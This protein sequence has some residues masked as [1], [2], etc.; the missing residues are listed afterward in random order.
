MRSNIMKMDKLLLL[1]TTF[2]F[3]L[4]LFMILSASSV[5]ASLYGEPYHYFIRQSIILFISFIG[6]VFIMY[7]PL[8]FFKKISFI[9][10]LIVLGLLIGVDAY[11]I[12]ANKAQS[13]LSLGFFNLQP[14]E[15][16]KAAI[17]LFMA[18]YYDKHYKSNNFMII[19]FP[20]LTALLMSYFVYIQPDLGTFSIIAFITFFLF[21][22]IPINKEIKNNI[23]KYG[24]V[25]LIVGALFLLATDNTLL[26]SGQISRLNYQHPCSNYLSGG[27][28]YQVCNGFI[29]INSGGL[30]GVGLGDSTQK[31]LY[32][33][34]A[35]TDFIFAIT[36]EELGLVFGIVIVL[37]YM[38]ILFLI[39]RIALRSK[40]LMGSIIAYGTAL[41]IFI[42]LA[43]NIAGVLGIIPLTGIPLPFLSYGGSYALN[44]VILLA[45]VQKVEIQNKIDIQKRYLMGEKEQE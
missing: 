34:E 12:V 39:L 9:V 38:T 19:L 36:L 27:K 28:G 11:G 32:L 44:L 13:W 1:L 43:I 6:F 14:S 31:Y 35:H 45:L 41:Y 15:F 33:P 10:V 40:R 4:G 5:K 37:I 7:F 21:I 18:S 8:N 2:M 20:L 23:L 42:H 25:A 3:I 24:I 16:V 26:K 17:I 22:S 29:A 30:W